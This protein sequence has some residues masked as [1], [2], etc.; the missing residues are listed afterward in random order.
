MM[1]WM[2]VMGRSRQQNNRS[3]VTHREVLEHVRIFPEENVGKLG[4]SR[5]F[6]TD[7]SEHLYDYSTYTC[8][9]HTVA[10]APGSRS[11]RGSLAAK[12]GQVESKQRGAQWFRSCLAHS[13]CVMEGIHP[14]AP[15]LGPSFFLYFL[16]DL[17]IGSEQTN[18]L[19]RAPP[20]PFPFLFCPPRA[21]PTR[22]L[23]GNPRVHRPGVP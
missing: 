2:H 18:L 4:E 10:N 5:C 8:K 9:L 3:R 1:G 20:F 17:L 21:H 14:L 15:K 6:C 12:I 23:P 13:G 7:L 11:G 19:S 22:P 16:H